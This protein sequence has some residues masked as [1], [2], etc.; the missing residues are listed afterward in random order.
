M[1]IYDFFFFLHNMACMIK[2]DAGREYCEVKTFY[3]LWLPK[4]EEEKKTTSYL[5]LWFTESALK[6]IILKAHQT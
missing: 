5:T 3:T 2:S 4:K 1:F 6:V